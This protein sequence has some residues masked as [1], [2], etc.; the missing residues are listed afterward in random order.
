MKNFAV[1]AI[2]RVIKMNEA[3]LDINRHISISNNFKN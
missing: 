3:A 2:K 1:H